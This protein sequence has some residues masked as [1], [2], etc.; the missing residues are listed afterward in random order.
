MRRAA[1]L[2][3]LVAGACS[4]SSERV[5]VSDEDG[6][7]IIVLEAERGL[8]L[9]RIAVGKRPRGLV[10]SPD[11]KFLYVALSG[12]PK[13][14]PGVDASKLPP[15]DRAADGIGVVSLADLQL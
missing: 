6:G 1:F 14:P 8:V 15:A 9:G 7:A 3:V 11:G 4:R 13:A 12:S 10:V 5:F 2:L